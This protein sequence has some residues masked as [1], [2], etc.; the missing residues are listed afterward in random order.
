MGAN[1]GIPGMM[2]HQAMA[3]RRAALVNNSSTRRQMLRSVFERENRNLHKK[4][5]VATWVKMWTMCNL[6][7]IKQAL[8]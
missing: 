1:E 3:K 2:C 4:N 6:K 8:Q 7:E 5:T